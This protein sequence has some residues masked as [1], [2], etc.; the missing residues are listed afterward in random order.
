MNIVE[1]K[2]DPQLRDIPIGT[3]FTVDFTE[4]YIKASPDRPPVVLDEY[5]CV[6]MKL[7][8]LTVMRGGTAVK[9]PV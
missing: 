2:S 1:D 7:G 3:L 8:L 5:P 9:P 4:Y 6:D